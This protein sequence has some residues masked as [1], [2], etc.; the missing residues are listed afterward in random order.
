MTNIF[1]VDTPPTVGKKTDIQCHELW[2]FPM[3]YPL[4][5][6]GH[7]GEHDSLKN[8]VTLILAEIFP[9]F[10]AASLRVNPSKTGRFHA[11]KANLHV[12]SADEINRLYAALDSA[13]TVKTVV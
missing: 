10:D 4:S 9:E 7:E 12:K 3:D 13:K 5:V 2:N 1:Q 11:V 6:I 8:E